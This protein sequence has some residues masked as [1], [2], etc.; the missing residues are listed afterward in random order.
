L[1]QWAVISSEDAD[2]DEYQRYDEL[3]A[4]TSEEHLQEKVN[5]VM[6]VLDFLII[7]FGKGQQEIIDFYTQQGIL[8]MLLKTAEL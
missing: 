3:M 5:K 2:G 6:Q 4:T 8:E 7:E 1:N